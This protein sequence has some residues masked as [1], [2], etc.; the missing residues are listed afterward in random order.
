MLINIMILFKDILCIIFTCTYLYILESGKKYFIYNY[1]KLYKKLIYILYT[2]VYNYIYNY[3]Y[4]I[5]PYVTFFSPGID[6]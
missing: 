4:K 2:I 6:V 1:I 3:I 5:C